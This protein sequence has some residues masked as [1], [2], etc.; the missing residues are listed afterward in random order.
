MKKP[1]SPLISTKKL[2]D[3]TPDARN[4]NKGT[5]RGSAMIRDSL[6]NY[7]AGRSILLD[8]HGAIIAGN[9]TAENAGALGQQEVIIVETDG[10]QL[11][12]V[13][14]TD[15]DL[16][17]PRARQLAIADNR[18]SEVSLAWDLD[19]LKTMAGEGIDLGPFWSDEEL[20]R[21]WPKNIDLL[22]EDDEVPD[23]PKEP[24]SKLGDL[25]ILGDHRLLCGDTTKSQDL[26]H[27]MASSK[28]GC[29]WS[30]PPYNLA[31]QAKLSKEEAVARNR[32]KDGLEIMNDSMTEEK[33]SRFLAVAFRAAFNAAAPGAAFYLA[34]ADATSEIFRFA[35]REAG[36][37]IRQ[38]LIW[39]K[40]VFVMGRQDYQ[41]RH[42][43]I[44][45]GWKPGAA[46]RWFNDRSQTTILQFDRPRRSAE[47]PTMK[48][49]ALVQ[50]CLCNSSAAG[51]I[52]LDPFGGSGS[53][54]IA[55]EK[56]GRKCFMLELDP[57][58]VDVIVERWQ[59]ATGKKAV[60]EGA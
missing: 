7:G 5:E 6:R 8:K 52:V 48:P 31:Y 4:A 9:K 14:R 42:E 60:L 59:N 16:K 25:W 28:A 33:F 21:L 12:A 51:E 34:H 26:H 40:N 23:T 22:T 49:V 24:I 41:W 2:S 43:P 17:D 39:E 54:L 35:S 13:Q 47:H 18:T 53:T 15:L 56:V 36:W 44:L 46:H 27:L 29:V 50:Y 57:A 1:A 11:V 20:A 58:Y 19:A 3:L 37:T 30:D 32:R 45:Y 55:C 38:C 10:S